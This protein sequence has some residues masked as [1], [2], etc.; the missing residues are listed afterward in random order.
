LEQAA[1]QRA[2]FSVHVAK[3]HHY[4]M[5]AV[6]DRTLEFK[7]YDMEGRLFDTFELTKPAE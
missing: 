3:G 7:A 2:W 6:F 4:C 1:P 5:A